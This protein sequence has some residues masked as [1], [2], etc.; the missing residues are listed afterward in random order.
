MHLPDEVR[1]DIENRDWEKPGCEY[2]LGFRGWLW[3]HASKQP[4]PKQWREEFIDASEFAIHTVGIHPNRACADLGP[5]QF[6]AILGVVEVLD[7]V[8]KSDS[9][10]FVGPQGL[11]LGRRKALPQPVPAKGAQGFWRVPEDVMAQIRALTA[12]AA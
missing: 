1:K 4:N 7:V 2:R 10:W 12:R 8:R 9:K 11:V 5:P 3:I 6:G